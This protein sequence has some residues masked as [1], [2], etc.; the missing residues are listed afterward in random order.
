[1]K[2]EP[3]YRGIGFKGEEWR[4]GDCVNRTR[5]DPLTEIRASCRSRVS[6]S[7][8]SIRAALGR[9]T[10]DGRRLQNPGLRD[11]PLSPT[12]LVGDLCTGF[13]VRSV[14]AFLSVRTRESSWRDPAARKSRIASLVAPANTASMRFHP[15]DHVAAA[16]AERAWF[17]FRSPSVSA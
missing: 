11:L 7:N 9:S 3:V 4:R 6:I 1:M 5:H 10:P 16:A 13:V 14:H 8:V 17:V 12:L 15:S 2:P